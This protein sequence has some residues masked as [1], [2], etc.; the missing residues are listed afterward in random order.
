MNIDKKGNLKK[1][2]YSPTS[3]L[4][5]GEVKEAGVSTVRRDYALLNFIKRHCKCHEGKNREYYGLAYVTAGNIR[6]CRNETYKASVVSSP[7][8]YPNYK[9]YQHA[10]ILYG[11]IHKKDEPLP[12]EINFIIEE[13]LSKTKNEKDEFPKLKE[14]KGSPIKSIMAS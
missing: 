7:A 3:T 8:F 5:N 12:N 13:L 14:W 11:Y 1:N 2:F 9:L 4:E 10:D 6:S